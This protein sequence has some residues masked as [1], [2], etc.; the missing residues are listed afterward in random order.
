MT[1]ELFVYTLTNSL[2]FE[3]SI[4]NYGGAVTSL[5]T[6]DREGNFGDIVLSYD[7]LEDYVRNP[8]YMGALIGRHA[9]RIA[10]G[11]FLLNGVEYQLPCNDGVNHLHGGF[12]GF[13]TRVWNARES[14]NTVH[15]WYLSK[16]SEEG[17]PG[18]LNAS[19]DYIL[20][21]NELHIEYYATTDRDTIVNLTNHSYFNLRGAGTILDHELTLNAGSFTPV[22]DDLIPTGEIKAVAGTPMDFRKAKAIGSEIQHVS[23]DHNFVLN[24]WDGSLQLAARLYEPVT[25]RTLEILT[26]EP[27]MQFYSGNFLDGSL[28][29][30]NGVAYEK[31]AGLCL[32]PQ[33]FPD[34]PNHSNF[35][36][37]VLRPGE[38]YRHTSI[39]RFLNQ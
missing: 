10:R 22:S 11:K 24:D 14:G 35:P 4:T 29:G 33:H 32:E 19:V 1:N 18:N 36:S 28:I 27:G 37:T 2:G 12:K 8:R 26:T 7:T 34:A 38:E 15:L 3:V 5:K 16:D 39:Y 21:D 6:P 17:Y 13:D 20:L 30:K 25:G 23:Y 9:N 31:Y